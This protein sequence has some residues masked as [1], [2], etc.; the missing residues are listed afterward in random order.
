M[1]AIAG[2]TGLFVVTHP[3]TN[4]MMPFDVAVSVSVHPVPLD[5]GTTT[6]GDMLVLKRYLC[7][8][9]ATVG[10]HFVVV[11]IQADCRSVFLLST[12]CRSV[13]LCFVRKCART[14]VDSADVYE[15]AS[16]GHA[17]CFT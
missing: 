13:R 6:F 12:G 14:C 2:T 5:G 11:C 1:L 16:I 17:Y 8:Y 10:K 3:S 9:V 15:H 7:M 4:L